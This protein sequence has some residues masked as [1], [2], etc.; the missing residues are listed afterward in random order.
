[1][2]VGKTVAAGM[3]ILALFTAPL[4][5][6]SYNPILDQQRGDTQVSAA[7]TI[8][9]GQSNDARRTAPRFEIITRSTRPD[10]IL[11]IVARDDQR[12]WDERRIGITLDGS[13]ALMLNG[14]PLPE[15]EHGDGVSTF[16]GIGI[17][18]GVLVLAAGITALVWIDRADEDP[19]D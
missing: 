1:M 4:H 2:K 19:D 5:A 10:S 15:P 6:Q 11:P 8:P 7:I 14:E 16:G 13:D 12:R 9:L 18:V 17:G 3:A